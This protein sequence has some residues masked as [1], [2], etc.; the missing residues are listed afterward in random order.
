MVAVGDFGIRE[1]EQMVRLAI[2]HG[3]IFKAEKEALKT[4]MVDPVV[5]LIAADATGVLP[6]RFDRPP[7]CPEL[8]CIQRKARCKRFIVATVPYS[9]LVL[10]N[11]AEGWAEDMEG[12]RRKGGTSVVC[13]TRTGQ[14]LAAVNPIRPRQELRNWL[15]VQ[16][17]VPNKDENDG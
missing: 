5:V 11:A 13:F 15:D 4:G 16:F 12:M 8:A 1:R 6:F 7:R 3:W 14:F 17:N 10:G 9:R 2:R